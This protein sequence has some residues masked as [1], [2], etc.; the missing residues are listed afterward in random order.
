MYLI[1]ILKRDHF[2]SLF[3]DNSNNNPMS[4]CFITGEVETIHLLTARADDNYQ[5]IN[6]SKL[7]YYDPKKNTWVKLRIK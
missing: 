3:F 1:G 2:E 4:E 6:L 5:V 7:E